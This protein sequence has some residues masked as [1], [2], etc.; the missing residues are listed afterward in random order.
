MCIDNIKDVFAICKET[1]YTT[2]GFFLRKGTIVYVL[3]IKENV[4][5]WNE[6]SAPRNKCYDILLIDVRSMKQH[7]VCTGVGAN[8]AE[9]RFRIKMMFDFFDDNAS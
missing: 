8:E 1:A 6:W 4:N 5:A 2:Q 9:G 7:T 3:H